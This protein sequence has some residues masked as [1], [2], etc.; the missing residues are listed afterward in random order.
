MLRVECECLECECLECEYL[1]CDC[2]SV[3]RDDDGW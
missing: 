2:M 1:E 3:T